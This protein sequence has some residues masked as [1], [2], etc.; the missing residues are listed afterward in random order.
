MKTA[1]IMDGSTKSDIP[2]TKTAKNVDEKYILQFPSTKSA[3]NVDGKFK[4]KLPSMKT[5]RIMDGS[6]N[7][8]PLVT[9]LPRIFVSCL[10]I[11]CRMGHECFC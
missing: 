6:P 10:Q 7:F 3:E 5:A 1:R 2:S 9:L 4:N 8:R 11:L